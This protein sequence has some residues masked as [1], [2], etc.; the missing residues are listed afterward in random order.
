MPDDFELLERELERL[1]QAVSYP[2]APP[3]AAAVRRRLET[4]ARPTAARSGRWTLVGLAA[5][6]AVALALVLGVWAP[7]REAVADFFERLRIFQT[8]ES[9]ADLPRE[10]DGTPVSLGQAEERLGFAPKEATCPKGVGLERVLLQE[11][12][13]FRSVVL[14]YEHGVEPD[15]ALFQTEGALGKGLPIGAEAEPVSGLGD[16][17]YWLEGLRIVEYYDEQG[18]LIRESRRAT[19]ANTLIWSEDGFVFRVEGDLSQELATC[20]ARSLR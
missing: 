8:E 13:G 5:A 11:F 18:G 9:P 15:F 14:F 16:Q 4:Q 10:I 1:S 6:A 17:A 12:P 19:D 20:V 2:A 3:L 7:G